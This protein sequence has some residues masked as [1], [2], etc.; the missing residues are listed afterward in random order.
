MLSSTTLLEEPL[1]LFSFNSSS[2]PMQGLK[3]KVLWTFSFSTFPAFKWE[4]LVV[5][6]PEQEDTI[7]G[8]NFL[9]YWNPEI[10]WNQGLINLWTNHLTKTNAPHS[11]A[12]LELNN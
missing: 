4:F 8:Y 7:L 5:D 12:I 3:E 2:E 6:A 11:L 10:D 9:G 1:P